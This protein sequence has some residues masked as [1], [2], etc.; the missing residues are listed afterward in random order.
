M[1]FVLMMLMVEEKDE[2]Y[3]CGEPKFEPERPQ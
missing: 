1:M 3:A 2:G